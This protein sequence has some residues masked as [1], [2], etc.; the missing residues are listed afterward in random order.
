[1]LACNRSATGPISPVL[2]AICLPAH[3]LNRNA[4]RGED[5]VLKG[6]H[7]RR[8]FVDAP[9]EGD[10][11]LENGFQPF[12]ILKASLG[13]LV[14]NDQVCFGRIERQQ[15]PC[16]ELMIQPV[17]G[18]VLQ[19]CESIVAGRS[20]QFVFTQDRLLFPGVELVGRF[21]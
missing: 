4:L 15:F 19:I 13:I 5:F 6:V 3:A 14:F 11:A 10:R 8:G 2:T 1:M 16:G 12:A 9:D 20:R 17:Y 18:P 21:F 7:T